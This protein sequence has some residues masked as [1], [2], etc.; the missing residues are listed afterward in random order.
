MCRRVVGGIFDCLLRVDRIQIAILEVLIGS[1][2]K[3]IG[4]GDDE[5]VELSAGGVAELR[6]VDVLEKYKLGYG[7][8]GHVEE[9]A[10]DALRVVVDSID[11]EVVVA[12]TLTA[13]GGTSTGAEAA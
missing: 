6:G 3:V 10:G 5:A 13:D 12:R 1:A 8:V 7:L 11:G 9:R 4:A 2:V